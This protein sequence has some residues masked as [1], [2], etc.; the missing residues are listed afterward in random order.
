MLLQDAVPPVVV[1]LNMSSST[2]AD[3][4]AICSFKLNHSDRD[5]AMYRTSLANVLYDPLNVIIV[6]CT[7]DTCFA[8]HAFFA[9]TTYPV[10]WRPEGILLTRISHFMYM[11]TEIMHLTYFKKKV[12]LT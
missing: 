2:F 6:T 4:N 12:T 3:K 8:I 5:T 9:V 10:H 11:L 7:S 1:S